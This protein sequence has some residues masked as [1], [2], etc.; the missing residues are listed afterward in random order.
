MGPDELVRIAQVAKR[1]YIDGKT[2]IEIAEEIGLSRFKVGR[3]L[4]SA[5]EQGVVRISIEATE[6]VDVS[7]SNELRSRFGLRR[8]IAVLTPD[9]TPET[10]QERIGQ[11]TADLLSE[12]IEEGDVLGLTAGRTLTAMAGRLI[13]V[14]PCEVVQLAGVASNDPGNG[15]EVMRNVSRATRGRAHPIFAPLLVDSPTTASALRREPGILDTFRRFRSLTIAAVAIGSWSPP[16]S[17]LYDSAMRNGILDELL[18][19][20]VVAEVCSTLLDAEG[21]EVD[22]I[23]SRALAIA[24]PQLRAIPEVIAAAGGTQKTAAIAAAVRSGIVTSL[25]TDAGTARRLLAF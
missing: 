12:V 11:A 13:R 24:T 14:A 25:V 8:A 23:A 22:G 3:M 5:L 4:E 10:L 17:Q 19:K 16:D 7:L 15:V 21:R 20:G 1:H 6:T 2:R 9:D 18:E